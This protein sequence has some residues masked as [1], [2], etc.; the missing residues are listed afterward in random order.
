VENVF[1][2]LAVKGVALHT[3]TLLQPTTSH[4]AVRPV[5][6]VVAVVKEEEAAHG[7]HTIGIRQK[8]RGDEVTMVQ[9]PRTNCG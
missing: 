8:W 4:F 3:M 9:I 5:V 1:L 6:V 7:N 2:R